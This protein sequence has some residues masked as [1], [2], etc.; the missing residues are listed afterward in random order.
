MVRRIGY[1]W[2][3]IAALLQAQWMI[4]ADVSLKSVLA[5]FIL[6][7]VDFLAVS[8]LFLMGFLMFAPFFRYLL[9][10]LYCC[11]RK[12]KKAKGKDIGEGVIIAATVCVLGYFHL[13]LPIAATF[14]GVV[15]AWVSVDFL[16]EYEKQQH[17]RG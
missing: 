10:W 9:I 11:L 17:F 12:K 13:W 14:L 5:Y 6:D 8:L 2:I 15:Y 1:F 3:G 4:P 7:P 16:I